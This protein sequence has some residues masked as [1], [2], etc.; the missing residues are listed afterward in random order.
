YTGTLALRRDMLGPGGVARWDFWTTPESG[1][2]GRDDLATP[3]TLAPGLHHF[4][5][6]WDRAARQKALYLDGVLA[7]AV[8]GVSLPTDVGAALELSRWTPGSAM[9]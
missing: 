3:D 6:S 9:S 7:V 8:T 2:A 5:I 1:A 4:V